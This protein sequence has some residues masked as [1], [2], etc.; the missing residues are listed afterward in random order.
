MERRLIDTNVLSFILKEDTRAA[1]YLPHL[2]NRK[3][4]IAFMTLAEIYHWMIKANWN[5]AKVIRVRKSLKN[6][7]MLNYDDEV[8]WEWAKIVAIKGHPISVGDAWIG[9]VAMRFELPWLPTIHQI[10][11][12]SPH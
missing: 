3:L 9:A 4:Y 12:T 10:L 7:G 2:T 11:H 6:Y 8:G 5:P 1:R